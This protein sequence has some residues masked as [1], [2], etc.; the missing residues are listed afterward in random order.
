MGAI[1]DLVE[2]FKLDPKFTAIA[3]LIVLCGFLGTKLLDEK[4]SKLSIDLAAT[5][6]CEDLYE[7]KIVNYE[8]TIT[9]LRGEVT[10]LQ[11]ELYNFYLKK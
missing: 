1:K 10:L 7:K 8:K 5:K 6:R 11:K 2:A 9:D 3:L 4:D